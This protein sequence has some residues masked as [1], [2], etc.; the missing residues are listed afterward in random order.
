MITD[1]LLEM[2]NSRRAELT[3]SWIKLL[4]ENEN[5]RWYRQVEPELLRE[6]SKLIYDQLMAWLDWQISSREVAKVFWQIGV[7]RK[8]DGIPLS[9]LHYSII[10]A[11]RNLYINI[12]EKL[13]ETT[14]ADMQ[15][16]IAF[17]SR[18][19]YFFDKVG[20]FTIKGYE[21]QSAPS[22]EDEAVL[23]EILK[24]FREGSSLSS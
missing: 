16:V 21:G 6:R 18:I 8:V 2:L 15:D 14:E 17:T 20:Y 9:E 24:A 10:L 7:E 22:S 19:T 4:L 23:D 12:L 13:G 3:A 5:T 1:R 11:R